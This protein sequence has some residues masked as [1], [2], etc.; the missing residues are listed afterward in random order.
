MPETK[1]DTRNES[2]GLIKRI[3]AALAAFKSSS[4]AQDRPDFGQRAQWG[5][6][7][8]S[9]QYYNWNQ[10]V[11]NINYRQE[12]GDL[13]NASLVM[14]IVNWTGINLAEALPVVTKPDSKSVPQIELQH[15]A[16][17]LIRRPNPF[18]IW[19]D[20]CQAGAFD[21]W[22]GNWYMK[23]VRDLAGHVI[24]L[25]YIPQFLVEPRWPFDGRSPEVPLSEVEGDPYQAFISH[26]QYNI[27]GKSP[28]LIKKS[29]MIHIKR[30][31]SSMNARKG[32]GV[33]DSVLEEVYGDGAVA[34]FS[35]TILKNMG[36][37]GYFL[38]PKEKDNG[39]TPEQ[40]L[41]MEAKFEQKTT[42]ENSNRPIVST[43][44]MEVTTLGFNPKELD[45]KELRNVPESRVAG[46][47]GIPAIVL[48][49]LV[50]LE[51]GHYGSAY[52]Q[53][54]QQGYENVI[55]PIQNHIAEDL[56]WQLLPELDKT[57]GARIGFDITKVRVLQE[58]RDNLYKREADALRAGGITVN[59]FLS[60]LGKDAVKGG[61]I[62]YVP[63]TSLP[64][65]LDTLIKIAEDPA[66]LQGAMPAEQALTNA[67]PPA[68]MIE[69]LAD[70]DRMFEGL[71]KQMK[72]FAQ[73]QD[74]G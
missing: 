2:T 44:A 35:A 47:T 66:A 49:F 21:W 61:D 72:E 40:A 19:A 3:G 68:K 24:E 20:Y 30:G 43:G 51:H 70:I 41:A 32:E 48:Q 18:H 42:G 69:Q 34:R 11:R 12:L 50:G 13:H 16:S 6:Q 39:P 46:V 33:W 56:T 23:K 4:P 53:A 25:W 14:A 9:N 52:E 7:Y 17:D 22:M 63:R 5:N 10:P 15:E 29:E 45:L 26:Y 37:A 31:V 57:Q 27:P 71:E 59:Q 64:L 38:S 65:T 74:A 60:S 54:R 73:N 55:I 1:L 58:D 28:E 36:K 67:I 62:Y 8:Q